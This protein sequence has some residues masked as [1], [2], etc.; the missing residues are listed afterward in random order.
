M[1]AGE[2]MFQSNLLWRI[3]NYA[4]VIS[5]FM[6][7]L[8]SCNTAK[9]TSPLRV[10]EP[11]VYETKTKGVARIGEIMHSNRTKANESGDVVTHEIELAGIHSGYGAVTV[12]NLIYRK[13]DS[14][15]KNIVRPKVISHKLSEGMIVNLGGAEIELIELKTDIVKYIVRRDFDEV[16]NR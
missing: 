8:T 1:I 14:V 12:V 3:I 7:S 16:L 13:M 11:T 15:G 2:R 5:L 4:A 6:V 9:T 10:T